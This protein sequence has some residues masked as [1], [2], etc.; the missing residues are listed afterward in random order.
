MTKNQ[1]IQRLKDLYKKEQNIK[2]IDIHLFIQWVIKKG[3]PVPD[4]PTAE[5]LLAREFT[6]AIK[7]EKRRDKDTGKEY[8]VN[9]AFS[10]DGKGN[11]VFW[12]DIDEAPRKHIEKVVIQRREQMVGDA[13]QLVLIQDHWNSRNPHEEPLNV[14]LDFFP[15]V[16]WKKNS[17]DEGVA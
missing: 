12:V 11:G 8:R 2:E 9:Y 4:P 14:P 17:E 10:T 7:E 6:R 1:E 5:E 16:Q 15:D 13:Y 3:Y